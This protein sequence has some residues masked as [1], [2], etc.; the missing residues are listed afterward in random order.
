[1]RNDDAIDKAIDFASRG[2]GQAETKL[3]AARLGNFPPALLGL[4]DSRSSIARTAEPFLFQNRDL[5]VK[6]PEDVTFDVPGNPLDRHPTW[7]H[8]HC[9]KCGQ[10]ATP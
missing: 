5:P 6:L 2:I 10:P 8:V 7:R 3:Q 9:P 1:M 4:P